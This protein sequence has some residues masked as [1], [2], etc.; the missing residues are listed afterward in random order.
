MQSWDFNLRCNLAAR[1]MTRGHGLQESA[2]TGAK[3]FFQGTDRNVLVIY[4]APSA[5][6]SLFP[7]CPMESEQPADLINLTKMLLGIKYV[8]TQN[9]AFSSI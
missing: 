9:L 5:H 4:V 6:P 1:R 8:D 2:A 7:L 3:G